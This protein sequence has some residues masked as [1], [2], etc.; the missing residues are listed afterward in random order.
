MIKSIHIQNIKG[1]RDKKFELNI[2]PNK[3][4]ILVAPNG[5]GK[6][7][8]ATAFNAMNNSRILLNDD[9]YHE[10]D[11]SNSPKIT[12]KYSDT[13]DDEHELIATSEANSISNVIDCYVINNQL[14][15]KGIG[16]RFGTASARLEIK[17]IILVDRIPTKVT[18]D[19]KSSLFRHRFGTCGRIL[20]NANCV[21]GNYKLIEKL[22]LNYQSLERANG[23]RIQQQITEIINDINREKGTAE[24]LIHWVNSTKIEEFRNIT[25]LSDV[26]NIIN[27]VD[28]VNKSEAT[29]YLLALQFVWL[30][31]DNKSLFKKA[32]DYNNYLIEKLRFDKMLS[33]FNSTWKN[34]RAIETH[35]QL[36]V[37]FPEATHISNGQRD[38]LTFVSMLFK[39]HKELKKDANI[40]IIDE[41]FDYLDDAN[42]IVAQ[43]YISNLITWYKDK[44]KRIYPLILTHLN[45]DYFRNYA[46]K[47]QKVYHLNKSQIVPNNNLVKLLRNRENIDIKDDVSKFL[48]HS[49][50]NFITKRDKF[51][52]LGIS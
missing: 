5:F 31:N 41:V 4:S 6:S 24:Q 50:P 45:P 8:F 9:D 38:I 40:L 13:N 3:P 11:H 37:K 36:I 44:G 23:V 29:S 12:L 20:P 33:T 28:Y 10:E 34:I 43:Y 42:L 39:A 52:E 47:D 1:I 27:E 35:N 7:S 46:F 17:D 26:A 25:Y 2:V 32:C 51:R 49:N 15:P 16:S 48:L 14:K 19:Y 21:L 18:I 22:S 30:Y